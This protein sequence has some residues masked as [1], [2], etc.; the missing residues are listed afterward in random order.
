MPDLL[1]GLEFYG[2]MRNM[3]DESAKWG[4]VELCQSVDAFV[5]TLPSQ[6]YVDRSLD[7]P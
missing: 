5:Y 3:P 2:T 7:L 1:N 6:I 4:Y